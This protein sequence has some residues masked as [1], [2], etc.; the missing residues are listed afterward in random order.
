[1]GSIVLVRTE[2]KK[3]IQLQQPNMMQMIINLWETWTEQ[4]KILTSIEHQERNGI[5]DLCCSVNKILGNCI[6]YMMQIQWIF[7]SFVAV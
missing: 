4:M 3:K 6:K 7:W 1:M 5:Q 2:Q